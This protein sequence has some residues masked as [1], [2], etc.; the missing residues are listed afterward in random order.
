[1]N[2]KLHPAVR[3][4]L[5]FCA[6]IVCYLLLGILAYAVP[7]KPVQRNAELTFEKGDFQTDYPTAIIHRTRFMMDNYSD[8]LIVHQAVNLRS[9]GLQTILLLPRCYDGESECAKLRNTLDGHP[10]QEEFIYARY[11]HG[12]TFLTRILLWTSD[13]QA[14]RYI[15]YVVSSLVLLWCM[16]RLYKCFGSVAMVLFAYALLM[17][18]VVVMQFSM[19]FVQVLLIATGAIIYL[20]YRQP[21]SLWGWGIFFM[22]LGSL[23]SFLDLITVP[24][25]TLGLPLVVMV[26]QRNEEHGWRGVGI[27]LL[28][29]LWWLAGYCGTWLA[30][31]TIATLLTDMN[32]FHNAVNQAQ[33]WSRGG[34]SYI[35]RSYAYN[36]AHLRW[37]FLLVGIVP[38]V[39]A[40]LVWR[41]RGG[42][43]ITLQYAVIVLVPFVYYTLM[44]RPAAEH[45]FFNYRALATAL[46]AGMMALASR[47]DWKRFKS[48][49]NRN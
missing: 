43:S 11:W 27:L 1:M 23:T 20:T 5:L 40:T 34:L 7:Q 24:S 45:N 4:A 31:W 10:C 8:A 37:S 18:N 15:L 38:L 16:L 17:V 32:V 19:Q 13:Y 2:S 9:K 22:V 30:K 35:L 28:M 44:A 26:A 33:R 48:L 3:A 47:V 12:S 25:I 29:A 21:S 39:V 41:K 49:F 46:F 36:V 42:W 14:I 6:L